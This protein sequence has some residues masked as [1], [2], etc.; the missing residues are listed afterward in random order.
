[1]RGILFD[2]LEINI[3]ITV[4]ILIICVI[5]GQLRKRYGAG[6]MKMLWLLLA[7]RLAVPYN[8]SVPF[9]EIRLLDQPGFEQETVHS[10]GTSGQTGSGQS[11]GAQDRG[12]LYSGKSANGDMAG[13]QTE[14]DAGE[15]G[16]GDMAKQDT[17]W[18]ESE[19]M[20]ETEHLEGTESVNGILPAAGVSAGIS[21]NG[22]SNDAA[23]SPQTADRQNGRITDWTHF[24]YADRMLVVW[25]AGMGVCIFYVFGGWLFFCI[26]SGKSI[27]PLKDKELKKRILVIQ[28]KRLGKERI[29]VYQ[30][31]YITSPMLVGIFAPKLVVPVSG[32]QWDMRELELVMEHELC[33]YQKKDLF[34]K[35]LMTFVWCMNWFNPA[36]YWMKKQ[37]FY[38]MELSCDESVLTGRDEKAREAYARM[39]LSAAGNGRRM[40][41]FST[42]FTEDKKRMVKRIDFIFD[43]NVRKRGVFGIAAAGLLMLVMSVVVSCGY[44]PDDARDGDPARENAGRNAAGT[45]EENGVSADDALQE[46]NASGNDT[47]RNGLQTVENTADAAGEEA[48]AVFDPNHE[49][50]EMIRVYGKDVYIAREDGIYWLENGQGEEELLFEN[51]Y[52]AR[53]GMELDQ[54]YL[55]FCGSAGIFTSSEEGKE[56]EAAT[57]YRMDLD[58][59]KVTDSM[60]LFSQVFENLHSISIYEGNLYVAQGM[61]H[62]IG[63]VLTPDGELGRALDEEADDFLYR[64]YNAYEELERQLISVQYD[65]EEYWA[66][67]DEEA[68]KYQAVMDVAS[69]KEL[70]HGRQLVSRYKDEISREVYF[71]NEDGSYEYLCDVNGWPALVTDTG[72]YYADGVNGNLLY[73][74]FASG[75]PEVFYE[76]PRDWALVSLLTYDAE[77]IYLITHRTVGFDEE[78]RQVG[79]NYLQRIPRN[80]GALEKVYQFESDMAGLPYGFF[81]KC[82]VY[83]GRLYLTGH[84]T[85][86]L[87]PAVNGMQALNAGEASEDAVLIRNTAEG[88]AQAYFANDSEGCRQYLAAEL[89]AAPEMYAYPEDAGQIEETY[90][91]GLPEGNVETGTECMI[92]YEFSGHREAGD[93]LCYLGMEMHK[94]PQGWKIFSY[95]LEM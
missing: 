87:D 43:R 73:V 42:G 7:L 20:N 53:R 59:H 93:A 25:L 5:G 76:Q 77:Y 58:T 41:V 34:W 17:G 32:K 78:D 4:I 45:D 24:T 49:Y 95:G 10:Q 92:Y 16:N 91:S 83:D 33:H 66:L 1:M 85:I 71:E 64:E 48:A 35:F 72:L 29:P 89:S 82:G 52:T 56:R 46:D 65:S 36:V 22:E 11:A 26:K 57:I 15:Y 67:S 75:Q 84:E 28:K 47:G 19:K 62:R 39:V 12:P 74:D 63:F 23:G 54:N 14:A 88:F 3:G 8:I 27:R 13:Q 90:L 94:T 51:A 81:R 79:E 70:L 21:D 60:A 9:M 44:R 2:I 50:N 61:G 31:F 30:S 86:D 55:Y 18:D 6:W 68:A 37:F 40:P 38:D 80:G 69:C